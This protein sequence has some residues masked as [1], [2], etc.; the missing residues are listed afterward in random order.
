M[1]KS[2]I[3]EHIGHKGFRQAPGTDKKL[4][5]SLEINLNIDLCAH[6]K[7]DIKY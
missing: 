2:V 1:E 5:Q 6:I 4:L 7:H 3:T